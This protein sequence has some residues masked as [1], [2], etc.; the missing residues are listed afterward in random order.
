[1]EEFLKI[2]EEPSSSS[3]AEVLID[4]GKVNFFNSEVKV[5]EYAKISASDFQKFS[6]DNKSSILNIDTLA[7]Y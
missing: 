3:A 7:R 1:M 6:F 4:G 2:V 5:S